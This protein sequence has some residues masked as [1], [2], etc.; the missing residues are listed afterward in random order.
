MRTRPSLQ[1]YA[2]SWPDGFSG[3]LDKHSQSYQLLNFI[4]RRPA[5]LSDDWLRMQNALL[6]IDEAQM[7]YEY[8]N[9]WND[10]FKPLSSGAAGGPIVILFSSYGS[11]SETPVRVIPGSAP[12]QLSPQQR[13]SVRPLFENNQ[14]VSMYFTRSEFNDVVARVCK[15]HNKDGQPFLP[16]SELLD[17][18]WEFTN[19]HP[20]GTRAVLD[21]LIHS[22]VSFSILYVLSSSTIFTNS[23]NLSN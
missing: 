17:Y 21:A 7:S 8:L 1:V 13:V 11:P 22:D 10:F 18:L 2:F 3:G 4:T 5:N 16:S 20:G 9:L 12:I 19:G 6:V 23:L 14:D 15:F